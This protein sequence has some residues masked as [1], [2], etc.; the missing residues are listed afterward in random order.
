MRVEHGK[1]YGSY[2]EKPN[3]ALLIELAELF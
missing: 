2:F 1:Q 3:E